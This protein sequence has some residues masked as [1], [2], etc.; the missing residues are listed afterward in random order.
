VLLFL[1]A[2]I[3]KHNS[4]IQNHSS[5]QCCLLLAQADRFT[6]G[7]HKYTSRPEIRHNPPQMW[8]ED[9]SGNTDKP[10]VQLHVIYIFCREMFLNQHLTLVPEACIMPV[11]N[12]IYR[13]PIFLT[14]SFV[15]VLFRVSKH[16][17]YKRGSTFC[18]FV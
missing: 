10:L 16:E 1:H 8:S 14:Y 15:T 11:F 5:R 9:T 2:G 3:L 18:V 13:K 7:L 12:N 6:C 4:V 17:Y